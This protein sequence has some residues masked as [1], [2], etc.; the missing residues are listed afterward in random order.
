MKIFIQLFDMDNIIWKALLKYVS[1]LT[2]FLQWSDQ[3]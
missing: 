3:K 2:M 1:Y